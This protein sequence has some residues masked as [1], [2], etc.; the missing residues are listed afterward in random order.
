MLHTLYIIPVSA[1]TTLFAI[2]HEQSHSEC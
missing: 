1:G 2:G